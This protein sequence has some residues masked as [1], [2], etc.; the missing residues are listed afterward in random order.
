MGY[1][2]LKSSAALPSFRSIFNQINA[3]EKHFIFKFHNCIT[4]SGPTNKDGST[5]SICSQAFDTLLLP[6]LFKSYSIQMIL[7]KHDFYQIN[8]G[9]G[10]RYWID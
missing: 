2:G 8:L 10:V 3:T 1:K 4:P 6:I 7:A 9:G 5:I